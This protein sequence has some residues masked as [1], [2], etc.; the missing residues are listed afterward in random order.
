MPVLFERFFDQAQQKLTKNGTIVLIFSNILTLLRPDIPHPIESEL[1]NGR[2][3]LVQ[4]LRRKVKPQK[5]KRTKEK[6]EVWELR[7][8]ESSLLT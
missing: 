7:R 1:Q 8:K 4:K 5:G 3:E 6:V 2:F